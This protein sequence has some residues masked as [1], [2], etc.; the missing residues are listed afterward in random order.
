V[1]RDSRS[2]SPGYGCEVVVSM[3]IGG[4][5]GS[6][7]SGPVRSVMPGIN[8]IWMTFEPRVKAVEASEATV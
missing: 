6:E 4:T 1:L 2:I 7:P 8:A 5:G 3:G